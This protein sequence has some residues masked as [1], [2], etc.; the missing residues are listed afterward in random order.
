MDENFAVEKKKFPPA[1]LTAIIAG[2]VLLIAVIAIVVY[3]AFFRTGT[4]VDNWHDEEE[5]VQYTFYGDNKMIVDT[6]YGEYI[7]KYVYDKDTGKGIISMEGGTIEFTFEKDKV[8]LG[9]G[10]VLKRGVI[11]VVH[12]V[13]DTTTTPPETTPADVTTTPPETTPANVTTE[14]TAAEATTAAET[15]AVTT[16]QETT[17]AETTI[18]ETIATTSPVIET[19]P[20]TTIGE[21]FPTIDIVLPTYS[22]MPIIP[23]YIIVGTPI[24][25]KWEDEE[26]GDWVLD[27]RDDGK[28]YVE[29]EGIEYSEYEYE[30]NYFTGVGSMTSD[31]WEF[32]ITVSGDQLYLILSGSS[33]G[34]TYN[35]IS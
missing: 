10:S 14:S 35:R 33:L 7:G 20:T 12:L 25:G 22:M 28:C 4:I 19:T 1:A 5:V 8:I 13:T 3:F 6:P 30:Y 32:E 34:E 24:E 27:F 31:P 2:G 26:T 18:L 17:T 23:T 29:Y 11:G 16:V 15:A 9:N 21:I